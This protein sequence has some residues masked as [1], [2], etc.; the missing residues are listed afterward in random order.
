MCQPH[1]LRRA[2]Q[3]RTGLIPFWSIWSIATAKTLA[4]SGVK[5]QVA[6]CGVVNARKTD[7]FVSMTGNLEARVYESRQGPIGGEALLHRRKVSGAR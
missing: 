1:R 5:R 3:E 6:F 2:Y 7:E 4:C